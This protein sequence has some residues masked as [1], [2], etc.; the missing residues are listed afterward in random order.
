MVKRNKKIEKGVDSLKREIEEHF[1]KLEEDI[2]EG[3]IDRGKY[4]F[5]EIEKSLLKSL[6]LKIQIIGIKDDSIE[7]FRMRLEK[8]KEMLDK[9]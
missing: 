2:K 7:L 1:S 6:E 8:I 3:M 4:H 5:K 9:S